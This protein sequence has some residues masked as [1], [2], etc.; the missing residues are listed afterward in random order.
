MIRTT[1]IRNIGH[2][3]QKKTSFEKLKPKTSENLILQF[4]GWCEHFL[5]RCSGD[6]AKEREAAAENLQR[7]ISQAQESA[8]R[9][10]I[11]SFFYMFFSDWYR[12]IKRF[13]H[14]FALFAHVPMLVKLFVWP[15]YDLSMHWPC[16]FLT[17]H[18]LPDRGA[19]SYA[20]IQSQL[21]KLWKFKRIQKG[22]AA[23]FSQSG[24]GASM[25]NSDA[26]RFDPGRDGGSTWSL[27]GRPACLLSQ[28]EPTEANPELPTSGMSGF[29]KNPFDVLYSQTNNKPFWR[30][31]GCGRSWSGKKP[32]LS[33]S[34]ALKI[35]SLY[36]KICPKNHVKR[37]RLSSRLKK[38][39]RFWPSS[40]FAEGGRRV[41]RCSKSCWVTVRLQQLGGWTANCFFVGLH[42]G[43]GGFGS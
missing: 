11:F 36:T 30:S 26:D 40:C 25:E 19:F 1:P 43:G 9:L 38:R 6:L 39:M 41:P 27:P 33:D 13:A 22:I 29:E 8:K 37:D 18:G 14:L 5:H 28:S 35:F 23:R 16:S 31:C 4:G 42:Q 15:L 2:G 20:E 34:K 7:D 32:D 17:C 21:T 24:E 3:P 12:L 10:Q